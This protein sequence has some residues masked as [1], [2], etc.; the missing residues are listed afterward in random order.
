[1]ARLREKAALKDGA[2]GGQSG[3]DNDSDQLAPSAAMTTKT[4]TTTGKAKPVGK[5]NNGKSDNGKTDEPRRTSAAPRVK[6][7]LPPR[8]D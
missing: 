5:N 7:R 2:V 3:N 6:R 4:T 8:S 1:V